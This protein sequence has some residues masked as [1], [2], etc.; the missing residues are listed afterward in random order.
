MGGA[1]H[2]GARVAWRATRDTSE[3]RPHP[4]IGDGASHFAFAA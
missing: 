2:S 1:G 4:G 3:R